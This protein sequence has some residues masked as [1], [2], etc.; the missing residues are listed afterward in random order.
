M[1]WIALLLIAAAPF[2]EAKSPADWSEDELGQMF[3]DSP[4]AQA[5]SGPAN[6]ASVV[7]YLATAAP[8][9]QAERERARRS[10]KKTAPDPMAEEYR[11]WLEDNR[12][13]QIVVAIPVADARAFADAQETRHMDQE[14]AMRIGRKKFK[15]TGHF[16]PSPGDPFLRLAFPREVTAADKSVTFE[17]YVPGIAM[18]FRSVEFRVKD[19]IVKGKLEI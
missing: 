16:P 2:W 14:C 18:P 4:W 10:K 11:L 15:M 12:A 8:M 1:N 6:A 17:L 9:E 19:M 13:S 3:A 7:A 5:L